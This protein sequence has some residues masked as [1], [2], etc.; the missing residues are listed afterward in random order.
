MFVSDF[1]KTAF[2]AECGNIKTLQKVGQKIKSV[3]DKYNIF[4]N[5]NTLI[6]VNERNKI[7]SLSNIAEFSKCV[8]GTELENMKSYNEEG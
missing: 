3:K 6:D 1:S 2:N 7:N 4:G 5:K 8:I